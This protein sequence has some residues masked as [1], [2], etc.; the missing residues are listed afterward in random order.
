MKRKVKLKNIRFKL[1]NKKILFIIV[2]SALLLVLASNLIAFKII[3]ER[4]A[5]AEAKAKKEAEE[6][7]ARMEVYEGMTIEELAAKLDRS[8]TNELTGMG[9]LYASLSIEYGIDPYMAVAITLHETGCKWNCSSLM[10]NCHNVGGIVG[11]P[12]CGNS[13]YMYFNSLDEGI[14]AYFLNLHENYY[15]MG[16]NT[17]DLIAHKYAAGSTWSSKIYEYMDYIRAN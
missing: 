1:M 16:L 4:Q 6:V 13:S 2:L 10:K 17:V 8:L 3:K 5:E 9:S 15:N 11:K 14:R 7:P 12:S